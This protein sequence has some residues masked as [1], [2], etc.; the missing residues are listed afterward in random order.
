MPSRFEPGGITQLEALAAGTLVIGRR[1]G[2]ISSTVENFDSNTLRGNGFLCNDYT[3]TAF[4]NTCHWALK[5]TQDTQHYQALVENALHAPHSWSD[6]I[7]L[8][9]EMLMHVLRA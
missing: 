3:P 4:S 8:Y 5:A 7:P 2:G 1:V 6:R 9:R